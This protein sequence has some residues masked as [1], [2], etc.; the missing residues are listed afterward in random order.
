MNWQRR[1]GGS[2]A[3]LRGDGAGRQRLIVNALIAVRIGW[4]LIGPA[5]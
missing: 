1:N 2:R 4:L 3:S 5:N